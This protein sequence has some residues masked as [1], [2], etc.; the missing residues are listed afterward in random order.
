M[1]FVAQTLRVA[2]LEVERQLIREQV[3]RESEEAKTPEE[4]PEQV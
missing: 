3:K 2:T 1:A 4:T